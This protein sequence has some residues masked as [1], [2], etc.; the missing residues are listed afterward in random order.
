MPNTF[1]ALTEISGEMLTMRD[2]TLKKYFSEKKNDDFLQGKIIYF[3]GPTPTPSGK[4]IG[5]AGPTTIGRMEPFFEQLGKAGVTAVIGKGEISPKAHKI[6]EKY[7]VRAFSALGGAGAFLSQTVQN[8]E[9]IAFPELGA[10]AIFRLEVNKFP[11]I[12]LGEE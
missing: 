7:G 9:V 12:S 8:A 5:S 10:E 4:I 3:C 11:V 2:G 6:L 1:L